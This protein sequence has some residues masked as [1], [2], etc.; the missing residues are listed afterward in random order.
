MVLAVMALAAAVPVLAEGGPTDAQMAGLVAA[1]TLA[2]CSVND[3]NQ[4][5]VLSDAGLTADEGAAVVVRLIDQKVL[6]P[7]PGNV[8]QL[9]AGPCK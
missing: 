1:I 5:A 8:L 9:V 3:A 7:K 4:K 2:G 6:F